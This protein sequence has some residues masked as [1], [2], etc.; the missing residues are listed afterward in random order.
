MGFGLYAFDG[1]WPVGPKLDPDW[2]P[3]AYSEPRLPNSF[4]YI[5]HR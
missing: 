3:F 4:E 5:K 2:T 1:I